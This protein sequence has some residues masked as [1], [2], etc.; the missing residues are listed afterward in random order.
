MNVHC[1]K[2]ARNSQEGF[3]SISDFD[4][5]HFT[6]KGH[7][8]LSHVQ[9]AGFSSESL[10]ERIM[11]AQ[12]SV[13]VTAGKSGSR[14]R[15]LT[16]LFSSCKVTKYPLPCQWHRH[17]SLPLLLHSFVTCRWCLQR[18]EADQ[19]KTDCRQGSGEMQRKVGSTPVSRGSGC[20]A[21]NVHTAVSRQHRGQVVPFMEK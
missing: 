3:F 1:C 11:D 5:L 9:F 4:A 21:G 13:L 8:D 16:V 17:L 7:K 20:S 12:S 18:R 19:P 6:L 15:M 10:C 14:R 2:R